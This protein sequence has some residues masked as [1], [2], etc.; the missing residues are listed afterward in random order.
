MEAKYYVTTE[1]YEAHGDSTSE[2]F[3]FDKPF[4]TIEDAKKWLVQNPPYPA[5]GAMKIIRC[6][7]NILTVVLTKDVS[8]YEWEEAQG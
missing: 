6:D 4:N 5:W 1:G 7:N 3:H 8:D 2:Y